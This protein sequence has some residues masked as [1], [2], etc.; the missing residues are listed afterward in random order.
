MLAEKIKSYQGVFLF[1]FRVLVGLMF[2]QHGAMKLFGAFGGLGGTSVFGGGV[3]VVSLMSLAGFIEFFGGLAIALGLLTRLVALI[4]G[5]EMLFA[6]FMVHFKGGFSP[7]VNGGE[8][9]LLYFAAALV[10]LAYGAG[11]WSIDKSLLKRELV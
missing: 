9:A 8:I 7:I 1:M 10:L 4:S 6:Y 11:R 3:D 5:V 2:A